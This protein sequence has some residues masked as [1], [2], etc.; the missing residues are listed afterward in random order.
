ME[1]LGEIKETSEPLSRSSYDCCADDEHFLKIELQN[2]QNEFNYLSDKHKNT[3]ARIQGLTLL[4]EEF[5][6]KLDKDLAF[7]VSGLVVEL[8]D[9]YRESRHSRASSFNIEGTLNL[10]ISPMATKRKLLFDDIPLES[11]TNQEMETIEKLK[12]ENIQANRSI[13]ELKKK[14]R[15]LEEKILSFKVNP[16]EAPRFIEEIFRFENNRLKTRIC[17]LEKR[18]DTAIRQEATINEYYNVHI[19]T[20][21]NYYRRLYEAFLK[22]LNYLKDKENRIFEVYKT[23]NSEISQSQGYKT[24]SVNFTIL[25]LVVAFILGV[26]FMKASSK[27]QYF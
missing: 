4:L 20:Y 17:E 23:L 19:P 15:D 7:E 13:L 24:F 8:K 14:V 9:I 3:Q 27:V 22:K 25:I 26:F 12:E 21:L 11:E 16:G 6:K 10:K 18:I 5:G 2:A 1:L